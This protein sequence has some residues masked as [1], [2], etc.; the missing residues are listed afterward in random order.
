MV[1]P[2]CA[3]P[4]ETTIAPL[5]RPLGGESL[6][7]AQLGDRRPVVNVGLGIGVESGV[8]RVVATSSARSWIETS[9]RADSL[10]HVVRK[11]ILA[12][13]IFIVVSLV[14]GPAP[15]AHLLLLVVSHIHV[16][17][18]VREGLRGG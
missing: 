18:K 8:G 5:H 16:V 12:I 3:S 1:P 4:G 15:R 2:P 17:A 7:P 11:Q 14:P 10:C 6:R 9:R 13:F